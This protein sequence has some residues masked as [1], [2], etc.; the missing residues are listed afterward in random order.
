MSK[1]NITSTWFTLFYPHS[2]WQAFLVLLLLAVGKNLE[3]FSAPIDFMFT[4][5][6]DTKRAARY[7]DLFRYQF[8]AQIYSQRISHSHYP[9]FFF[10][11]LFFLIISYRAAHHR[12]KWKESMREKCVYIKIDVIRIS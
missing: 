9:A 3:N 10:Y 11:I 4:V 5:F 1:E 12:M 8:Y 2:L 6:T 7:L